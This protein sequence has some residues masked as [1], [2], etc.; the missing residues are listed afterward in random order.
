MSYDPQNAPLLWR[1]P[2]R[3]VTTVD[4]DEMIVMVDQDGEQHLVD[5][6]EFDNPW[7]A[8]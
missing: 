6:F 5:A 4:G 2:V 1:E 8:L 7:S 3:R